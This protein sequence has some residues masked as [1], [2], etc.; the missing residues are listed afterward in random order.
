[1]LR[2][3]FILPALALALAGCAKRD[4]VADNAVNTADL[5]QVLATANAIANRPAPEAPAAPAT[6]ENQASPISAASGDIPTALQ[7][8]WGLGPRDCT[9][10]LGDAK[11]LLIINAHELRFYESRAVP[12]EKVQFG[13]DSMS[14]EFHFTGEGQTWTKYEAIQ[15]QKDKLVRTETNPATSYTYARC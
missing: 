3:A 10:T 14:G 4:P 11:G 6:Q 12:D 8:R 7:G 9:T 15:R 13:T 2:I 5:N 1:M